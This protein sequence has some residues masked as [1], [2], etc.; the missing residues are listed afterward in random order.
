MAKNKIISAIDIG[1]S[2]IVC[3][4]AQVI[5]DKKIDIIGVC[6]TPSGGI[7]KGQIVNIEQATEMI[8]KSVEAA[9]RMAGCSIDRVTISIG[10]AHISSLNSHG[11][12]AVGQPDKEIIQEDIVRVIDA[13]RAVSLPSTREILHVLPR[14]YI[15]DSQEEIADP[16]GMCGVRLEV[17]T[18]IITASTTAVKNLQKCVSTLGCT[19]GGIVFSGFASAQS[20]LSETE[21]DL[22]VILLDI[23]GGTTSMMI[24]IE[25]A[26]VY[27]FVFPLGAINVT[28][29]LATGLRFS[30]LDHAERVKLALSQEDSM[31]GKPV[32]GDE[33]D[34]TKIGIEGEARK[35]SCKTLVDGII[36]PR[37]N[38]IFRLVNDEIINNKL[39]GLTPSGIVLTGGGALTV[40]ML[41]CCKRSLSLP[42]RIGSPSSFT[43]LVDEIKGPQYSTI[44]GLLMHC[45]KSNQIYTQR[46]HVKKES[47]NG[48]RMVK[49]IPG[50]IKNIFKSF[51]P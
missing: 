8:T 39:E 16:T 33:L 41:D 45:L 47:F 13:A 28:R 19:I 12:V 34:L 9:E 49:E 24:Y 18:H 11:V 23:G 46:C 15:V 17:E 36:K 50:K 44:Y 37:L 7:K 22:G 5:D 31:E 43:G 42:V 10:G 25:G 2:K 4:I 48:V 38:E 1:S 26:P 30:N 29:D 14:S 40:G 32:T 6:S 20:V 21:K 3:V 35:V 51:L 27:S